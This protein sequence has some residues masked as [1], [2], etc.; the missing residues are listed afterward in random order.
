MLIDVE[1]RSDKLLLLLFEGSKDSILAADGRR[2]LPDNMP[3]PV[4][5]IYNRA[6]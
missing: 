3:C 4:V 6:T 5:D 2:Q 1:Y